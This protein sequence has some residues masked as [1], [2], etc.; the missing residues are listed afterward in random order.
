MS[1]DNILQIK[2]NINIWIKD[3]VNKDNENANVKQLAWW[4]ALNKQE[5]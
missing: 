3:N 1:S 2:D 5:I 4:L